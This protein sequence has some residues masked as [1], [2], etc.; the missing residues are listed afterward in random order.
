MNAYVAKTSSDAE[1]L[2][3]PSTTT[4]TASKAQWLWMMCMADICALFV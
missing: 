3:D 1:S 4:V 2:S